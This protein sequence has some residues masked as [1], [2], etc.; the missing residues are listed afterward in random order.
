MMSPARLST[1]KS[2]LNAT[3][4]PSKASSTRFAVRGPERFEGIGHSRGTGGIAVLDG[5][6]AH[7]ECERWAA[8]PGGD[9]T[10]FVGQ[11]EGASVTAGS[12]LLYFQGGYHHLEG[13][14]L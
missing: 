10:I 11:V 3:S 6:V 5:I 8:Y 13:E 7:L 4:L 14:S 9:H 12:P 1:A 2:S